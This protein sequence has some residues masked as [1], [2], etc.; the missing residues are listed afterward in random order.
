M[1]H[2]SGSEIRLTRGDTAYLS[3]EITSQYGAIYQM[4]PEDILILSVKRFA[5]A[6]GYAL[7]KQI[8]GAARF[9]IEPKD[10]ASLALGVYKYDV[11][12][13]KANGDVHT[14]IPS[15]NFELTEEVTVW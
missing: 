7:Q 4:E 11:E 2:I 9:H 13:R 3:V 15:S 1:L 14:V 5:S 12:L 8:R 6:Q 10:T